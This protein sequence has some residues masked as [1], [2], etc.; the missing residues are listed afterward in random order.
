MPT[1]IPIMRLVREDGTV[2]L[3]AVEGGKLQ[4]VEVPHDNPIHEQMAEY[5]KFS[6][7][8]ATEEEEAQQEGENR[9]QIV[10][11]NEEEDVEHQNTLNLVR[12]GRELIKIGKRMVASG[13]YDEGELDLIANDLQNRVDFL[14]GNAPTVADLTSQDEEVVNIWEDT[15]EETAPDET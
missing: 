8:E 7:F 2:V 11:V 1:I 10:E 6:R 12:I 13:V 14:K 15:E 5:A 4:L 3:P 9:M